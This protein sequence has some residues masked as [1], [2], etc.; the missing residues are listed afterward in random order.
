[1]RQQPRKSVPACTRLSLSSVLVL[2]TISA[3]L[4]RYLSAQAPSAPQPAATPIAAAPAPAAA[5]KDSATQAKSAEVVTRDSATTFKVRVNLVQVRVVVRDPNGKVVD[6]LKKEDFQLFDNRKPQTNSTFSLE[7]P[8]SHAV[9][10][11]T[12]SDH[13]DAGAI[14][15]SSV[16][17]GLPQRFVTLL[18]DD[19]HLAME[20]AVNVRVAAAKVFD[21][22][23]PSDRV[24]IYTTS[25]QFSQEFTSDHEL[26][27]KSLNQV[28]ARPLGENTFHD[29]PDISY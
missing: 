20:D 8:A 7:T 23:A 27:R 28:I 21:S 2:L 26:L 19:L 5:A 25:G 29:C 17:A 18:F 1:M 16:A 14:E 22:M 9:P 13:P 6:N 3:F 24:A 4:G 10:N 11:L 12:V 15:K